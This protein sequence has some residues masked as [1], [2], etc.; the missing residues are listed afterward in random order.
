[1]TRPE[2]QS[3]IVRN[4][5]ELLAENGLEEMA[6]AFEILIN[7]SMK[8]ERAEFLGAGF[9]ERT[10]E[11][12]GHANGF[13]PK[14]LNS[15]LGRLDLDIPQVR[16]ID[17]GEGFYPKSLERGER[18]ERALKLAIA[19]MYVRGVSTRKVKRITEQLCGLNISSAQVSRAS[20]LLDEELESWRTRELGEVAYLVLDTRYE[21]VRHGGA[22]VD[23]AVLIAAG[24]L[25]NG[26]R[27]ILGT[28][29]SLSEAEVHWREFLSGLQERGLRG[30]RMRP[31]R[32]GFDFR[33]Q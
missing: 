5:L 29:V 20:A 17:D 26:K 24:V 23:C 12:R 4:A 31:T 21:K 28:S 22:V 7:E 25:P 11:R 2:G 18:S 16:N 27:T 13:K 3:T 6:T 9:Y 33:R 1:M 10:D 15:R 19:E 14:S 30:V 32:L 8:L